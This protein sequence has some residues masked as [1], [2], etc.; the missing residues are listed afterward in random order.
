MQI[1]KEK[2]F[3]D[4]VYSSFEEIDSL[5]E[6][7]DQFVE[8]VGGEIFLTFDWCRLWWKHYGQNRQLRIFMIRYKGDIIGLFPIFLERIWFGPLF[9]TVAKIVGSDFTLAQFTLPI[10]PNY[11]EQTVTQFLHG[12]NEEKWDICNLSPLTYFCHP[13]RCFFDFCA[14]ENFAF[15]AKFEDDGVHTIFDLPLSWEDNLA[16]LSKQVRKHI[17]QNYNRIQKHNI[18]LQSSLA[19]EKNWQDHF[20]GFVSAHQ[21]QWQHVGRPGHFGDWPKAYAFH[22]EMAEAQLK[23]RR[24]RLLKVQISGH[25][26]AYVYS[27]KYGKRYFAILRGRSLT[28]NEFKINL[29]G[30]LFTEQAQQAI[31]QDV[32]SIDSMRGVYEYKLKLGG[33]LSPLARV[34][35]VRKGL[36]PFLRSWLF[37]F[38]CQFVD[39]IYYRIWYCR[40]APK[41]PITYGPLLSWWIRTAGIYKRGGGRVLKLLQASGRG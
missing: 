40:I 19:T 17:R 13:R 39:I 5:C 1:K 26:Y 2:D 6:E 11:A 28:D 3:S 15:Q 22:R 16:K 21:K 8:S 34:R 7:W 24:L 37:R 14:N 25:E 9:V 23:K 10:N 4:S 30:L 33:R 29:G 12:L 36:S 32:E 18:S 41:I 20:D 38:F 27:Y 31:G 35:F